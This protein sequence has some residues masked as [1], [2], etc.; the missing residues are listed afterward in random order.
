MW[1]DPR[2][3]PQNA[4]TIAEDL[5]AALVKAG[6]KP[7]F[8]LVGHSLGGPY[9]MTYAKYFGSDV[10]GVVFVDAS[11]PDQVQRFK[12]VASIS[13]PWTTT[14][15]FKAGSALS[16]T[17]VVRA[18]PLSS[19][20]APNQPDYAVRAMSAYAPTS[21]GPMLKEMDAADETLAEAG[22]FRKL[23]NRPL[24]VLTASKP[25]SEAA[26]ANLRL[27]PDQGKQFQELLKSMHD[28]QASW[29]SQSQHQLVPDAGHYI[30]F[31]RPD[32][33]IAAVRAVVEKVRTNQNAAQ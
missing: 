1:S 10:A 26:L 2:D 21:L 33:V 29:S 4:K 17:G 19:K 28:E 13:P 20:G 22:T 15:M 7:P 3:G 5:H 6:E 23:G 31:D 25:L 30:Q 32:I 14:L 24:Y 18:S 12:A 8:V 27:T 9:V 16:W 11:H